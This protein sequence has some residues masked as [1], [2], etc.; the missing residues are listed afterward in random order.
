[1]IEAFSGV[2]D[3]SAAEFFT[4]R[5]K[6]PAPNVCPCRRE[7]V[8]RTIWGGTSCASLLREDDIMAA[9]AVELPLAFDRHTARLEVTQLQNGAWL[10]Y[11]KV[12]G[13]V[14]RMGAVHFT[15]AS[16]SLSCTHAAM[17]RPSGSA[18]ASPGVGRLTEVRSVGALGTRHA[19]HVSREHANR[20]VAWRVL[21][22][23]RHV[24]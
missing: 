6:I 13:R 14:H 22:H 2:L 1:M 12:D 9:N 4:D 3:S 17:A 10:V 8:L 7:W 11:T 19:R 21:P 24:P 15:R 16:G 5:V 18:R 23:R 20:R